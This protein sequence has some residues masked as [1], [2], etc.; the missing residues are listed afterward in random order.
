M[1][2]E[3]FCIWEDTLDAERRRGYAEEKSNSEGLAGLV[4]RR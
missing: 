3:A 4:T 2:S 1:R